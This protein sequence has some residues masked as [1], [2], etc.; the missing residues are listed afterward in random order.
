MSKL[1]ELKNLVDG[2]N[3]DIKVIEEVGLPKII[4]IYDLDIGK[5]IFVDSDKKLNDFDK[6][7]FKTVMRDN[8]AVSMG[9]SGGVPDRLFSNKDKRN[10]KKYGLGKRFDL[11]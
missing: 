10:F 9:K 3:E 7:L 1:E 4:F 6:R 8:E 2:I 5:G 11:E